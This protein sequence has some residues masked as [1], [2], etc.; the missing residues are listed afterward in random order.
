M[1]LFDL[2]LTAYVFT[3]GLALPAWLVSFF[4]TYLIWLVGIGIIVIAFSYSFRLAIEHML[5]LGFSAFFALGANRVVEWAY[6][7]PRPFVA[8]EFAPRIDVSPLDGSF[9]SDHAAVAWALAAAAFAWNKKI[10]AAFAAAALAI[11]IGRVLAG[12]HYVLDIVVGALVGV[13]AGFLISWYALHA[14]GGHWWR[15]L[16]RR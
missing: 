14:S 3:Y 16:L 2:T 12:V 1:V 13:G 6:F 9:P 4:A 7:R 11:S 5:R 10:G 8:G 15:R